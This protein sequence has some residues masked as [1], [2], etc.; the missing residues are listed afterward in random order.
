MTPLLT[1]FVT[2][3]ANLMAVGPATTKIMKER[4]HQ[5]NR[6]LSDSKLVD[7]WSANLYDRNS[8]WQEKLRRRPTQ[9]RD[10]GTQSEIW[11]NAWILESAEHGWEFG[12]GMVW[13]GVG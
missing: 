7:P 5:G 6:S 2:G 1:M 12:N 13:D 9:Q 4:K 8:R 11:E 10:A 3:L